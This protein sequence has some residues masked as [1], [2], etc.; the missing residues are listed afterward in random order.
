MIEQPSRFNE[1]RQA[2][3]AQAIRVLRPYVSWITFWTVA[4][5]LSPYATGG[6]V[7][8]ALFVASAGTAGFEIG[9][10]IHDDFVEELEREDPDHVTVTYYWFLRNFMY[11]MAGICT[12][13]N[14]AIAI[15]GADWI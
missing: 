9:H 11:G 14:I 15:A 1:N 5:A 3:R 8:L 4:T 6:D 2:W 10:L 13:L 12:A 7:F